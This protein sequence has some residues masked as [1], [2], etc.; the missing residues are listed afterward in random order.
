LEA[1]SIVWLVKISFISSRILH[2]RAFFYRLGKEIA[3]LFSL[4]VGKLGR[5]KK[6]AVFWRQREDRIGEER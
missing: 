3:S 2:E 4:M 6:S 1:G 5:K